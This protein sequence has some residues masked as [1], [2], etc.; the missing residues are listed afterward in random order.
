[1]SCRSLRSR[2]LVACISACTNVLVFCCRSLSLTMVAAHASS[3]SP[4]S[5]PP[6]GARQVTRRAMRSHLC[7]PLNTGW[8]G[9]DAGFAHGHCNARDDLVTAACSAQQGV[10]ELHRSAGR[11]QAAGG[12]AA[13]G[14]GERVWPDSAAA[15]RARILDKSRPAGE[16]CSTQLSAADACELLQLVNVARRALLQL[17]AISVN[18]ASRDPHRAFTARLPMI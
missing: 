18:H 3:A 16:H 6:S 15:H 1:M 14:G 5:L 17:A 4:P 7:I 8:S 10:S 9:F 11:W 13:A 2:N 12:P